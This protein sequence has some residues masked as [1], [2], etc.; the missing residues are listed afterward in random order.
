MHAPLNTSLVDTMR[1]LC[2]FLTSLVIDVRWEF[3]QRLSPAIPSVMFCARA[4]LKLM[5][6]FVPRGH[7]DIG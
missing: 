7:I 1:R 3:M 6:V 5:H 4:I 2:R